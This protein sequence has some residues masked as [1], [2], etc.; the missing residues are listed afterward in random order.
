MSIFCF[1][2]SNINGAVIGHTNL[3]TIHDS[4]CPP[5]HGYQPSICT[6]SLRCN[7]NAMMAGLRIFN[8]SDL[9]FN[10]FHQCDQED[11]LLRPIKRKRTKSE[12]T[13]HIPTPLTSQRG[14]SPVAQ[15]S[16]NKT[17]CEGY[18]WDGDGFQDDRRPLPGPPA[19][20]H[21]QRWPGVAAPLLPL[22]L[23]QRR[24]RMLWPRGRPSHRRRRTGHGRCPAS[25]GLRRS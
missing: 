16:Y 22:Q 21:P 10:F 14:F 3:R 15:A 8:A 9:R 19:G 11:L 6:H 4:L 2:T 7:L 25:Q 17:T 18:H 13:T 24:P 12:H 5:G 23:L 20:A 1:F